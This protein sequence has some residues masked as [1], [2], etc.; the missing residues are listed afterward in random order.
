MVGYQSLHGAL[1]DVADMEAL[2]LCRLS[3]LLRIVVSHGAYEMN[4]QVG[5]LIGF[6]VLAEELAEVLHHQIMEQRI[7]QMLYY[8]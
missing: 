8:I 7:V 5:A 1:Q 2:G 4:G 3:Q 6:D